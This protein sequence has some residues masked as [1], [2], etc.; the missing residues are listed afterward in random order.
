MSGA[1]LQLV[2]LGDQDKQL[3]GNPEISFFKVVFR[4][5][6]NF[7]IEAVEIQADSRSTN[8][9]TTMVFPI[10]KTGDLLSKLVLEVTL[11]KISIT[12]GTYLNWTNNTAHAYL[13]EC[14]I[15]FNGQV[16]DKH[17][18]EWLDIWNELTDKDRSQFTMLNKHLC[19]NTYLKSGSISDQTNDLKMYIP[20]QFWFCRHI[21]SSLPLIALQNT[22]VQIK[23]SF[24]SIDT[25]INTDSANAISENGTVSVK[26]LA[27]YIYLEEEERRK[28]ANEKHEYLIEQV[29]VQ[30]CQL[31]SQFILTFNHPIKNIIWVFRSQNTYKASNTGN[32]DATLNKSGTIDNCND[33]LNYI[34]HSTSLSEIIHGTKSIEPFSNFTLKLNGKERF[35]KRPASYFRTVEPY[36]AEYNVPSKH[37]YVY[38]FALHPMDLQPSGTLNFSRID[39]ITMNFDSFS[40]TTD[41]S[42]IDVFAINYN[43]LK[44]RGGQAGLEFN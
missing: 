42:I 20:L 11:P 2:A 4:K 23:A 15:T 25:I 24:R 5:H 37:I 22:S 12:G 3:T 38:S 36:K 44:I 10:L 33:Y 32:R 21:G 6:T 26:L 28:F 30:R 17:K 39:N 8:S 14:S 16:I 1:L 13:K 35:Q 9:N 7:A 27:D 43:I 40:G 34:A 29:K 31:K 19:K 18:G 41:D